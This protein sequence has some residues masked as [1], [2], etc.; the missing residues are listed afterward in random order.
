[1]VVTSII[2]EGSVNM[3]KEKTGHI[4]PGGDISIPLSLTDQYR[5]K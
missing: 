3:F 5:N 1:M 2:Y 4:S